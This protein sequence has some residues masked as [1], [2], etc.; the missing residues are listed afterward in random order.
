MQ[1]VAQL[2]E[3]GNG[4]IDLQDF[5]KAFDMGDEAKARRSIPSLSGLPC[6]AVYHGGARVAT[7]PKDTL[8]VW[9]PTQQ[10]D[11]EAADK[12]YDAVITRQVSCIYACVHAHI[13]PRSRQ[14]HV[15]GC[16]HPKP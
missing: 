11:A 7:F 3:Q 13:T 1:A 12:M 15:V 4:Y 14:Q 6:R 5:I 10:E 8:T 2:D 16:C 9:S